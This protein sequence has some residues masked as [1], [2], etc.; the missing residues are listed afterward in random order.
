MF[1]IYIYR[2]YETGREFNLDLLERQLP[3][4][5]MPS[6]ARFS[7]VK[8]KSI[9]IEA[10]PLLVKLGSFTLDEKP[11]AVIFTAQAKIFDIGAISICLSYEQ[12]SSDNN[13]LEEIGLRFSGQRGLDGIYDQTLKYLQKLLEPGLDSLEI[14]PHFYEDYTIYRI[15]H[16]DQLPDPVPLLMGERI[17]FS[18]QMREQVLKNRLSYSQGDFAIITWDTALICELEDPSDLRDLIEFANVQLLELRY[19]DNVLNKQMDKMYDD[20][21]LAETKSRYRK[22]RHYRQIIGT[23]MQLIADITE[24]REK[25]ENLIKITEDIYYARVY[26]TTLKVLRSDQWTASLNRK[27]EVI[28]QNYTLLSSEVNI[29]HS[30]YLE[31]II[32]VLIALEFGFAILNTIF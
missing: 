32:I 26:Q 1:F 29:Q 2:I 21:E 8:T 24:V 3:H 12:R 19:Y 4:E 23:R 16:P 30:Y 22:M 31:W 17:D 13:D 25:I 15:T 27:L 20:I 14:D 11:D 10:P 7:R 28:Q 9:Q 6:R 5:H 18:E